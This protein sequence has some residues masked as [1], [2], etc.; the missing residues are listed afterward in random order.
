MVGRERFVARPRELLDLVLARPVAD[1]RGIRA[2]V[3]VVFGVLGQL[4]G[5]LMLSV[6]V[7]DPAVEDAVDERDGLAEVLAAKG[8]LEDALD[9]LA[10]RS[11]ASAPSGSLPFARQTRSS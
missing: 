11:S 1:G 9:D 7:G 2:P 5:A 8:G 6:E 10:A 4:V 3:V